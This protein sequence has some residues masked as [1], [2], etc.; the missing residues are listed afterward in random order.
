MTLLELASLRSPLGP[1]PPLLGGGTGWLRPG[2]A[3]ASVAKAKKH[4]PAANAWSHQ[5]LSS[6]M[7]VEGLRAG[8]PRP[9]HDAHGVPS[10]HRSS[11]GA[12]SK[13]VLPTRLRS[14]QHCV[15]AWR[16]THS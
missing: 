2:G 3:Q 6:R 15:A 5:P 9:R 13:R 8:G 16:H 11:C 10:S 12:N 4:V 1:L 7:T 14:T